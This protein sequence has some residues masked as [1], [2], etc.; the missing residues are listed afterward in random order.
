MD[1]HSV[2]LAALPSPSTCRLPAC[3]LWHLPLRV[4]PAQ[5]C[6]GGR[7]LR[8]GIQMRNYSAGGSVGDVILQRLD[9][10]PAKAWKIRG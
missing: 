5:G 4:L 9:P 7:E 1:T 10:L 3:S 6:P 8:A 2:L